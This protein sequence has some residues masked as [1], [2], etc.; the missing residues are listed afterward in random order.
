MQEVN[1]KRNELKRRMANSAYKVDPR[2]LAAAII[3]RLALSDRGP[4]PGA[5]PGG[6]SQ[7]AN[8]RNPSRPAI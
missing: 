6:P 5:A 4:A 2:D 1:G 8:G 3:V 7:P